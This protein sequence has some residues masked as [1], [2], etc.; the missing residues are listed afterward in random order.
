MLLRIV[1]FINFILLLDELILLLSW[2]FIVR[3][4]SFFF[5]N[6]I[7]ITWNALPFWVSLE[8]FPRWKCLLL[9]YKNILLFFQL[10]FLCVFPLLRLLNLFLTCDCSRILLMNLFHQ[11]FL[12]L[13]FVRVS[14]LGGDILFLLLLLWFLHF[15]LFF[16]LQFFLQFFSLNDFPLFSPFFGLLILLKAF[17]IPFNNNIVSLY[18]LLLLFLYQL[19]CNWEP[20]RKSQMLWD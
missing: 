6:D 13:L 7:F 15:L 18:F 19:V 12:L 17:I 10:F 20:R 14:L 2:V 9:Y 1:L 3:I 5:L 4:F 8:F 16:F 11:L